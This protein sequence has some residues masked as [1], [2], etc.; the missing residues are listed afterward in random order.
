MGTAAM[1]GRLLHAGGSADHAQAHL[2]G[3]Q[4]VPCRGSSCLHTPWSS[5]ALQHRSVPMAI[6]HRWAQSIFQQDEHGPFQV[7]R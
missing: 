2:Q 7:S 1:P 4:S 3:C 6:L 5:L